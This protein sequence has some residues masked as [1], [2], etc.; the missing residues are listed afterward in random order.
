LM[1]FHSP[2]CP[3]L[4]ERGMIIGCCK[5]TLM[6]TQNGFDY[7]SPGQRPGLMRPQ[8]N[9]VGGLKSSTPQPGLFCEICTLHPEFAGAKQHSHSRWIRTNESQRDIFVLF[10][11]I[12][13]FYVLQNDDC[14]FCFPG[15][16]FCFVHFMFH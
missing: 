7:N 4:T 12:L 2:S 14:V 10:V 6:K 9:P 5:S 13:M 16:W 11:C 15:L 8:M 1:F 3:S